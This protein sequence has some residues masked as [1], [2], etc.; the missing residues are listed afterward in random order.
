LKENDIKIGLIETGVQRENALVAA[1]PG[2]ETDGANFYT[3]LWNGGDFHRYDMD[4]TNGVTFTVA[5]VANIRDMAYD[6]QYFYGAAADMTL[7][8]MDLSNETLV[9]TI[10]ATCTGVTGIRHIA[11]DP[12]LDEGNGG[13]W[14]GNWTELGAIAMD[15]EFDINT[16]AMTGV[17]HTV[18]AANISG[19][20]CTYEADGLF[21]LVA[22]VQTDPNHII[23]YE[24]AVTA[25]PASPNVSTNYTAV[26][27]ASGAFTVQLDWNNPALNVAGD[28]LAELTSINLYADG[29]FETP[30]FTNNTP[31]ISGPESYNATVTTG[32]TH[33]FTVIGTNSNGAGLPTNVNVFVGV[34]V[35]VSLIGIPAR[36]LPEQIITPTVTVTNNGVG[37]QS[38]N[39]ELSDGGSYSNTIPSSSLEPGAS[40]EITFPNWSSTTEAVFTFTA[41]AADP[42]N[43]INM[44]NNVLTTNCDVSNIFPISD[45]PT[46]TTCSGKFTDSGNLDGQYQNNEY[47][48]TTIYPAS[49]GKMIQ[50]NFIAYDVEGSTYDFLAIYDGEDNTAP[51]IATHEGV[52]DDDYFL[53]AI[54]TATN[55]TGALTFE[56]TSDGSVQKNGWEADLS[57]VAP[58]TFHVTDANAVNIEGA[59]IEINGITKETDIDGNATFAF[60]EGSITYTV[61]ATFCDDYTD[62][63]VV[64]ADLG[65]TVEVELECASYYDI[66]FHATES[67]GTNED[68]DGA[69]ITVNHTATG[70]SWILDATVSGQAVI[71]LPAVTGYD[72]TVVA[73]GLVYT[74]ITTF[75]VVDANLSIAISLEEV[76]ADP[77]A[78]TVEVLN[79]TDATLTWNNIVAESLEIFQHDGSI[80]A[81]PNAYYQ[82]YN[83]GYG[84]VYD[85]T[86]YPDATI[87]AIDFHHMLWGL[88]PA[89]FEYNVHII[90]W[91]NYSTIGIIG[92][93]STTVQDNW[94]L[95]VDLGA[96]SANGTTQLGIF[97]EPLSNDAADAYPDITSDNTPD[98]GC[99]GNSIRITDLSDIAGTNEAS[100]IGD[101]FIDLW[102][103]TANS[104]KSIKVKKLS[105]NPTTNAQ[106]RVATTT[107]TTTNSTSFTQ[108]V[109]NSKGLQSYNVYL[110]DMTTPVATNV[111]VTT[112]DFTGLSPELHLA[113]VE[114]VY[115]SGN[116]E[117][118]TVEIDMSVGIEEMKSGVNIY[119]N[120]S[121]GTF[122]VN[123]DGTYTLQ[124]ID[125]TGK[126]ISSQIINNNAT[127]NIKN[128]GV[129]FLQFNN[130]KN[131]YIEKVIIK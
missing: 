118:I 7:F 41:T 18:D 61:A 32:G 48:V 100:T 3:T 51:L 62:S 26:A 120:P 44:D 43:D 107:V 128:N 9:S 68:I 60:A 65:Q 106:T 116:S 45:Y 99:D 81:S 4:G 10:T 11:Y 24:L 37:T 93:L 113:G 85:L 46:V 64:T 73:D 105:V 49:A 17:T 124:V 56:F 117:I 92:P 57:C 84:V 82:A 29:D 72:F 103:T 2:I 70:S 79:T 50:A 71:S 8:Q 78:L 126:V 21:I 90:D 39:V 123:V 94:E 115:E 22:N 33:T 58:V 36:A 104:A 131:R 121:N 13:F 14:I 110:D 114:A 52:S 102:I 112:Y 125:I 25:D 130:N 47:Y 55:E 34:D 12:T 5:G 23:A 67:W 80:P 69:V 20:A 1:S 31:T 27:D 30:I 42:G 53:G 122:K 86:T 91:T 76:I 101:F 95:N 54:F 16:M 28:P 129:Y 98:G 109:S 15:G 75:D 63:Y 89:T 40:E 119:P 38:F 108:N 87:D 111:D 74:G 83:Y 59:S 96:I 127:I 19:G 77:F 88:T 97:I 6:G 35:E 66:T